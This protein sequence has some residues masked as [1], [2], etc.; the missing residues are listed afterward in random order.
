MPRRPGVEMENGVFQVT[1]HGLER[2][3]IVRDDQNRNE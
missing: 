2:R 1:N 3:N